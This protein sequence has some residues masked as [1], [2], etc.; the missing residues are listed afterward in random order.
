ML[1]IGEFSKITGISIYMLRNYDKIGLLIPKYIAG[2]S[3]Y[4]YYG[5]EQIP[6]SNQIKV[7]KELGFSL[8][9]IGEIQIDHFNKK[10]NPSAE[11]VKFLSNK[12][13]EKEEEIKRIQVQ[14]RQMKD[15]LE[16]VSKQEQ[17]AL[18]VTIKKIPARNVI[19]LRD[20]IH[21]FEE[22]GRLWAEIEKVI[23]EKNILLSDSAY[24]FAITHKADFASS[25]FDVEVQLEVEKLYQDEERVHF[26]KII[27][28][29]AATLAFQGVY[30][31]IGEINS[32]MYQWVKKNGYQI[33]GK[34][35]TRYYLS[36]GN[37]PNPE[38]YV[39]EVCFPIKKIC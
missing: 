18:S 5:E 11:T 25:C 14:I 39:T 35:F 17:C 8:R 9:E 15:A 34:S 38:N 29:E 31:K 30:S 32:Y 23:K 37:E 7:L 4:R 12:I 1:K 3:G 26:K 21:T 6:V 20:Y 13:H 24:S 19:Y 36:P 2:D 16:E 10:E 33:S 22:E 28:C 27:E